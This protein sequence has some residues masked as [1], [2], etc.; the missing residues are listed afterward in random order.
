MI[1]FERLEDGEVL[2][3]TAAALHWTGAQEAAQ[4]AGRLALMFNPAHANAINILASSLSQTGRLDEAIRHWRRIAGLHRSYRYNLAMAELAVGDWP[5]GWETYEAR[6]SPDSLAARRPVWRGEDLNGGT[7][8]LYAEEGHGNTLQFIRYAPLAARRAGRLVVVVQPGLQ[9]LLAGMPGIGDVRASGGEPVADFDAHCPLI[10]LPRAFATRLDTVPDD[11]PYLRSDPA[12]AERW[13]AALP[14]GIKVGLA[15]AGD[16]RRGR[17]IDNAMD[18]RRSMSFAA[19]APLL[20]VPGLRFVSL[21]LGEAAGQATADV[22]A[23]RLIDPTAR[24]GDF[25]DT[26]GLM[27]NL[28]LV[29]TVDTAVAHLAG[30]LGRPVWVMSRFDGCWRWLRDRDD[31]PWYPGLRLFRQA[32]PGDWPGVV[33]GVAEALGPWRRQAGQARPS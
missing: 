2:G 18:R 20:D 26:A 33:A 14:P 7:L 23:G 4:Q 8:L 9:R 24:L 12:L 11:I 1:P 15:W 28:D 22:A 30:A 19:L 6:H 27:A 29:I 31:S 21:Q 3:L 17:L 13:R 16:P 25:A 32:A 5:R 10:S